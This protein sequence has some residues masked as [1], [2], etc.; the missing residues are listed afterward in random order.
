MRRIVLGYAILVAVWTGTGHSEEND[1]LLA[2]VDTGDHNGEAG[3]LRE[4]CSECSVANHRQCYELPS[5]RRRDAGRDR[6]VDGRIEGGPNH[7]VGRFCITP[8]REF[9]HPSAS[10]RF[11]LA[12]PRELT[13]D[14]RAARPITFTVRLVPVRGRKRALDLRRGRLPVRDR[15]DLVRARARLVGG[16][17]RSDPA[18]VGIVGS[19]RPKTDTD[20][21]QYDYRANVA[22]ECPKGVSQVP[23]FLGTVIRGKPRDGSPQDTSR[24]SSR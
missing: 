18:G 9:G 6:L 20:G 21:W 7:E 11:S 17:P 15:R 23:A 3:S 4:R 22:Y 5:L 16:R 12:I 14:V 10:Q 8:D 1:P 13:A 2:K 19:G 24:P